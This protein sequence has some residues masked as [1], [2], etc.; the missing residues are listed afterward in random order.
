[1]R[2]GILGFIHESNTFISSM[3]T[4]R[5][6]LEGGLFRGQEIMNHW[7]LSHHELGGFLK[8]AEIQGFE[9]VPLMTA[10][11][12]PGGPLTSDA[13]E[14]I[15]QEMLEMIEG[16]EEI[17][18]LLLALHGAM[19]AEG[20]PDAD[21]EIVRRIRKILG[22]RPIVM[23]LDC[24]AN[25]SMRMVENVTATI[26]YRTNPHIDQRDRGLEAAHLIAQTIRGQ[27]NPVQT[28]EKPPMVINISKQNS[29]QQPAFG[30]IQ[31]ARYVT[32]QPSILSAS[33]G[34]GFAF[35]D[36]EKMGLSFLVVA[37]GDLEAARHQTKWMAIRAWNRRTE[38]LGDL[39]SPREAVKLAM[40]YTEKPIVLMDVGDNVGGGGPAD[41]T[42][43]LEEC[44]KQ[45]MGDVLVILRDPKAVEHCIELGLN[46]TL[47]L[48]VGGK[49]DK[50]HGHPLHV[51]GRVTTISDGRFV[52]E[53][54]RHGGRRLYDQGPTAV[55]ETFKR[56]TIVLTT[57]RMP[58][59]SLEQILSLGIKPEA[60]RIIIVK[61]VI[62]PRAAYEVVAKEIIT[63][64][65][66]GATSANLSSFTYYN[67]R[68]PLF[69]FESE[70]TYP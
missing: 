19:V 65:T 39:P 50:L 43:L 68:R 26:L 47:S 49:T 22:N 23:T 11:A 12:T 36:V 14:S 40:N 4:I 17:D 8:G 27:I 55:L 9:V 34:M 48:E 15:L 5:S 38:F 54:P 20:Y 32:Q 66:P 41:S 53:Q 52:D 51:E 60:K 45:Q 37:D 13:F 28:L 31:D 64:D 58:P 1:M 67:R 44:M 25:I 10:H 2:I 69:P 3:T 61:G 56:N 30:L 24:H 7:R 70:T 63:V 6:F 62:A 42:I 16:E 35:A 57:H 59:F 21:G 46:A 33:V 29:N 18:G